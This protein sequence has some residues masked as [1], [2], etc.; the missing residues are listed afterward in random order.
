M[1]KDFSKKKKLVFFG[2][3]RFL[4]DSALGTAWGAKPNFSGEISGEILPFSR[5]GPKVASHRE[6]GSSM[7]PQ[8]SPM[9]TPTFLSTSGEIFAPTEF[10]HSGTHHSTLTDHANR[11]PEA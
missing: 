3:S 7:S 1:V 6:H 11:V 8:I 4:P 9:G 10:D 2:K 5:R